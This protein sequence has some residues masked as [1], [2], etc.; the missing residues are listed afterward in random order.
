MH[1]HP[2]I[3]AMV[4]SSPIPS[5][6]VPKVYYLGAPFLTFIFPFAPMQ[7]YPQSVNR[8]IQWVCPYW[9]QWQNT[10]LMSWHLFGSTGGEWCSWPVLKIIKFLEKWSLSLYPHFNLDNS[11]ASMHLSVGHVVKSPPHPRLRTVRVM[12][13]R[14][15]IGQEYWQG[16]HDVGGASSLRCLHFWYFPSPWRKRPS[17]IKQGYLGHGWLIFSMADRPTQTKKGR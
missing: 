15:H 11:I 17:F 3:K 14:R 2:L 12:T 13:V 9:D 4:F 7:A 8:R 1:F 5:Y 6:R 10:S 16:G